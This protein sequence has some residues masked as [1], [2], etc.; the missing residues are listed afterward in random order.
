MIFTVQMYVFN[1][2]SYPQD[3]GPAAS[4]PC[5]GKKCTS[6]EHCCDGTVCVDTANGGK[7]YY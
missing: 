5:H 2:F 7:L 4:D 6:N 3:S 1:K